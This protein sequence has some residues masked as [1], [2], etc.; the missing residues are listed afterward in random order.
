[1]GVHGARHLQESAIL[2]QQYPEMDGAFLRPG[3]IVGQDRMHRAAT[4]A[5]SIIAL[6]F[7]PTTAAL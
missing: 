4:T 3:E 2:R 1:M 5:A 6:V 7:T